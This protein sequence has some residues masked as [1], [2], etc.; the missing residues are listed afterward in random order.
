MTTKPKYQNYR[1]CKNLDGETLYELNKYCE[2]EG[3]KK[4]YQ[5]YR[6]PANRVC[7][8]VKNLADVDNAA[9][10]LKDWSCD[11]GNKQLDIL[12]LKR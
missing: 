4:R 10:F 8:T 7:V 2:C 5:Y 6:Q 12:F 11:N 3:C 1:T 9:S